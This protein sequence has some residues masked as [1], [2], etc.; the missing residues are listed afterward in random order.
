MKHVVN[1][2][3]ARLIAL[4][5]AGALLFPATGS[6]LEPANGHRSP[7][8]NHREH[9]QQRRIFNGVHSGELTPT[10][11]RRLEKG[12]YHIERMEVRAKSDGEL[13]AQ[14]RARLEHA[15]NRE[16]RQIYR[17]KHDNQER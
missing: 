13:T 5:F 11:F 15:L 12:E 3:T 10:E 4:G 14:E 2:W 6:A 1:T 9:V 8:I 7:G 16:S 17:Q